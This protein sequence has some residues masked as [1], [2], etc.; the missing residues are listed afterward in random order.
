V[1]KSRFSEEKIIA[2]L[3]QADAGVKVA[4]LVRMRGVSEPSPRSG[5]DRQHGLGETLTIEGRCLTLIFTLRAEGALIRV[6][7]ARD[8]HRK[9]RAL[10]EQ[11]S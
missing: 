3:K 9:E 5:S 6:I 10:Y 4:E 11:A 7:S 8:M 2:V 1:K